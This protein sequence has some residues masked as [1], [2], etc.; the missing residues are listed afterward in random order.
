MIVLLKYFW[1][2]AYSNVG[3]ATRVKGLRKHRGPMYKIVEYKYCHYYV[4]LEEGLPPENFRKKFETY[5][6]RVE[7]YFEYLR[8]R[9]ISCGL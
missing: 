7:K 9:K 3:M 8:S 5:D 1:L 4:R 2:Q 6:E